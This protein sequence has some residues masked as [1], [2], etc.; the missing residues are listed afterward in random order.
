MMSHSRA[1]KE[2]VRTMFVQGACH[3][4]PGQVSA[5]FRSHLIHPVQR[6][7]GSTRGPRAGIARPVREK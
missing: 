5:G 2:R 4:G 7:L 1:R 3:E 6:V